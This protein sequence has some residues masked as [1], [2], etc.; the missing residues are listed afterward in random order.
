MMRLAQ[1]VQQLLQLPDRHIMPSFSSAPGGTELLRTLPA[2][3]LQVFVSYPNKDN[4]FTKHQTVLWRRSTFILIV[5][6][7]SFMN[8]I[9]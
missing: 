6:H 5:K 4:M 2:R 9:K 1:R 7:Y 3:A 8:K